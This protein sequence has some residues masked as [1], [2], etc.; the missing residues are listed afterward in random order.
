MN[1]I[2]KTAAVAAFALAIGFGARSAS[3]A[4]VV[5]EPGQTVTV[6]GWMVNA[7]NGVALSVSQLGNTLVLEKTANFPGLESALVT[8]NAV[9][10]SA[11]KSIEFE[12]ESITNSGTGAWSGFQFLLL[13]TTSAQAS[14][15]GAGNVFVP[16]V[17]TGVDY[18]SFNLNGA[19]NTLTYNG[20]QGAETISDWGSTTPG[21]D[22]LINTN[23]S[24]NF[25]FDEVPVV[26]ATIPL[27]AAAWQG[28]V[29][30]LG[31]GAIALTRKIKNQLA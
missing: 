2:L 16:P 5:V 20:V 13:S 25:A 28:L 27:P 14:F 29:G 18:T 3:A 15:A 9:S 1:S 4:A 21:D 22:L 24:T 19:K 26:G 17:G 6:D 31:L 30:L 7:G 11:P 8:F 10:A 12:N 23:G